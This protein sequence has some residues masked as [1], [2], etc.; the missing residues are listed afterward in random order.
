ME[1]DEDPTRPATRWNDA[2]R[3]V[4]FASAKVL[5]IAERDLVER[6]GFPMSWLDVLAQLYDAPGNGLRMQELEERSLFTRSGLTRLVDRIEAAG[7]VRRERVPGD[8]RGVRVVLTPE[9]RRRHDA[10]F[11]E[12]LRVIEREFGGRLTP[13][14]QQAVADALAGFWHDDQESPATTG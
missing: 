12:H 11:V 5:R 7:L 9:G 8:R 2:W 14:E 1:Q 10:A 6:E 4:L 3:G 13:T